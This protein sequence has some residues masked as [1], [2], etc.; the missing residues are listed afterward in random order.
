MLIKKRRERHTK[1]NNT[2]NHSQFDIFDEFAFD[3]E[4]TTFVDIS[5]NIKNIVHHKI[6]ATKEFMM[7]K[8]HINEII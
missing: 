7:T 5:S 6:F 2:N 3:D 1:F 4:K 8:S